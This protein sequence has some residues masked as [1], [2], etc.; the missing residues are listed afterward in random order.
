MLARTAAADQSIVYMAVL[1]RSGGS[2]IIDV[3]PHEVEAILRDEKKRKCFFAKT[4]ASREEAQ[5]AL[6]QA[7]K[8]WSLQSP[9]P[10]RRR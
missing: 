4:F 10:W 6:N 9:R 5:S 8:L 3:F 7:A 1:H 2:Y